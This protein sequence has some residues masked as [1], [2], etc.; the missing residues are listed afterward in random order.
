M[1]KPQRQAMTGAQNA[2]KAT[3]APMPPSKRPAGSAPTRKASRPVKR[4]PSPLA[5]AVGGALMGVILIGGAAVIYRLMQPPEAPAP[6]PAVAQDAA[7]STPEPEQPGQLF[8]RPKLTKA[9]SPASPARASP[10]AA[11]P[12]PRTAS[13]LTDPR[14][15]DPEWA[16]VEEAHRTASPALAILVY[17]EYR[18]AQ[19]TSP[20]LADLTAYTDEALDRIW[21][22]RV[23]ELCEQRGELS[24]QL[25]KLDQQIATVTAAKATPTRLKELNED[26]AELAR[27]QKQ[28]QA[29]LDE[30]KFT[31]PDAPD[32]YDGD[33]LATARKARDATAYEA[34]KTKV[35][36]SIRT[37]RGLLPW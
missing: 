34:W 1:G 22:R 4:G 20:M 37:K 5:V 29:V 27:R 24:T 31:A 19:P 17:E 32:P 7:P 14:E 21:W 2:S 23:K 30:M 15:A 25:G 18:A 28:V 12:A 9:A 16:K 11:S 13:I 8:A 26:R 6:P 33:Q 10:S 36:A 3:P 35:V